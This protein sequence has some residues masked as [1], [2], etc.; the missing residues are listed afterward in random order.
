ME[1]LIIIMDGVL[2]VQSVFS[3]AI[4]WLVVAIHSYSCS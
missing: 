1:T 4:P 3:V 2:H